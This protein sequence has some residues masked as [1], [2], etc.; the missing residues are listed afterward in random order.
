MTTIKLTD[1]IAWDAAGRNAN[2]FALLG[3]SRSQI[4]HYDNAVS[5]RT[6]A[7]HWFNQANCRMGRR[8]RLVYKYALSGYR[9]DQFLADAII[10]AVIA[11]D[12]KY[13][14]V[15][16]IVN[17]VGADNTR[18][19]F[20]L[21]VKP[22]CEKLIA[23][24]ITP[25]LLTE[26]GQTTQNGN[27]LSLYSYERYNAQ[28]YA[29]RDRTNGAVLVFDIASLLRNLTSATI[30]FRT[31][32][33]ADGT[34]FTNVLSAVPVGRAFAAMMAPLV[35]AVPSRKAGALDAVSRG[36]NGF[37]NPGFLTLTGG[38]LG[39][40]T[41]TPFGGLS[42]TIVN[43]GANSV[44]LSAVANADGTN[45]L[46]VSIT[47][48]QAGSI[49]LAFDIASGFEAPGQ[50]VDFYA[51]CEVSGDAMFAGAYLNAECRYDAVSQN[52]SDLFTSA[53]L[54]GGPALVNETLDFFIP[55]T[56]QAGTARNW[57]SVTLMA[58]MVGAGSA[59]LKWR[60]VIAQKRQV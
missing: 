51:Q 40:A 30:A 3:T 6:N 4:V 27:A 18:D 39:A 48:S 17:D 50:N 8:M 16:S 43:T 35:P 54:G 14:I 9:T 55:L 59:T 25:I 42:G 29:Y 10:A 26:P 60:N 31:N 41:G 12:A 38:A 44:V 34:H 24:G 33:S 32:Y 7:G 46:Q 58:Y 28:L 1:A 47:A 49:R 36:I 52:W 5:Q 19:Y 2:H 45:D 37:P 23:A 56:V 53:D 15:D 22:A 13:C 11:T 20:N 57:F 21:T